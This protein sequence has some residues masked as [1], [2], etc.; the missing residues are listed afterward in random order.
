MEAL[1]VMSLIQRALQSVIWWI[2]SASTACQLLGAGLVRASESG[3]NGD[4]EAEFSPE[5]ITE[6]R[7]DLERIRR[8]VDILREE[9]LFEELRTLLRT[10]FGT[11]D[12]SGRSLFA[13]INL[14]EELVQEVEVHDGSNP[15]LGR[16]KSLSLKAALLYCLQRSKF[17]LPGIPSYL[18][19]LVFDLAIG[20]LTDSVVRLLNRH[21]LWSERVKPKSRLSRYT[22]IASRTPA[23][24]LDGLRLFLVSLSWRIVFLFNPISSQVKNSIDR[25]FRQDPKPLRKPLLVVEWIAA[26]AQELVPLVDLV[27]AAT[28]EAERFLNA[29]GVRKKAYAREVIL[30][31]I[32]DT[33]GLPDPASIS[34]E[35][36]NMV[37]DTAIDAVVFLFNKRA[38]PVFK[39]MVVAR[40]VVAAG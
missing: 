23:S 13:W 15:G 22:T 18:Q 7:R 29:D 32:Q 30:I 20:P 36:L 17:E 3:T 12:S 27:A 10:V 19:P 31:F 8:D 2:R 5:E 6:I 24:L 9:H 14:V 21:Q 4:S 33:V 38:H 16:Y 40:A 1:V 39:P 37:V 11:T 26:H 25:L 35:L 28:I 34:F